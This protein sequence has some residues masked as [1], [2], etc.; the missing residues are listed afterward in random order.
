MFFKRKKETKPYRVDTSQKGFEY[1]G[2]KLTDEQFQDLCILNM[3]WQDGY[4][5]MTPEMY[6]LVLMKTLNLLPSEMLYDSG[7]G[8]CSNFSDA[9]IKEAT[10][11]KFGRPR[12]H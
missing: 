8:S 4:Y 7:N 3:K 1:V 6:I 2:I 9:N 12:R 5:N 11:R 10:E